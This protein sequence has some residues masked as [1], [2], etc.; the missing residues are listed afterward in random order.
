[1]AGKNGGARPGAGR[2][3][4]SLTVKKVDPK[5]INAGILPLEMRLRVARHMWAE[6]T[7]T[8]VETGEVKIVDVAKAKEAADFAEAALPYTSNRLATM[9][10]VGAAGGAIQHDHSHSAADEARK[11]IREELGAVPIPPSHTTH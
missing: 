11:I 10:H 5:I 8:D 9:V 7:E 1:M 6:A 4:L 2:P 3:K